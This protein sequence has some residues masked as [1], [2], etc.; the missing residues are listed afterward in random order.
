MKRK[1]KGR[2]VS[3]K[4]A[5]TV[6]VE[7]ER[8][9]IHP[10]YRKSFVSTKRFLAHDEM[11]AVENDFVIIEETRPISKNKKWVVVKK[12]TEQEV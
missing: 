9:K 7:I 2:V 3:A 10:I 1:L 11:G 12:I 5:K 6:T 4:N 8:K